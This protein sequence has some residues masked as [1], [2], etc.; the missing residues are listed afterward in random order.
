MTKSFFRLRGSVGAD[1]RQISLAILATCL[2]GCG[3]PAGLRGVVADRELSNY[4]TTCDGKAVKQQEDLANGAY[5]PATLFAYTWAKTSPSGLAAFASEQRL[6]GALDANEVQH[7]LLMARGGLGK[8]RLAEALR[9]QLCASMPVFVVDL[10]DIAAMEPNPGSNLIV[11]RIAHDLGL[12][13]KPD[14]RKRLAEDF[15]DSRLLIFLDAIEE[16]DLIKR[17]AVMTQVNDLATR[18]PNAQ[19]ILLARPPVLDADYGFGNIDT[20]LEIPVLDCKVAEAF[21]ARS[22]RGEDER[23]RFNLFLKRNGLDEKMA[24]MQCSYLYMSTYRDIQTLATFEAKTRGAEPSVLTSRSSIY[25]S[26]LAARLAKEF[27][28]LGWSSTEELDMI[29]RLV[30][31]QTSAGG[32]RNLT[33]TLENCYKALDAKWGVAAVDA[34][35][36]GTS[37]Q[38]KQHVCEKTFQSALFRPADGGKG[39]V[40][41]DRNTTDLFLARWVNAEVART[42]SGDCAAVAKHAELLISDGV[43]RFF[44]GQ[45]FGQ[46]CLAHAID[47]VCAR[48][49]KPADMAAIFDDGLPIGS[50]RAQPLQEARAAASTMPQKACVTKVLDDLDQIKPN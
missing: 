17:I 28:N 49:E 46:R 15:A 13:T 50:A 2:V 20:K 48:A 35:V 26:L 42:G 43:M 8:S 38:R 47:S 40:L 12:D 23:A 31:Q 19:L 18:Y 30:R 1:A 4:R 25:E 7:V 41:S 33:F 36:A 39:F 11:E 37:E 45:T 9:A 34:G 10:K 6:A 3:G 16:V 44:V 22:Y 24:G 32:Q 5:N 27:E 21:V 14:A 29:D